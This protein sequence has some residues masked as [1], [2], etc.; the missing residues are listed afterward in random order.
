[1]NVLVLQK[2]FSENAECYWKRGHYY[3]K[4]NDLDNAEE[5]FEKAIELES[6]SFVFHIDLV[7]VLLHAKKFDKAKTGHYAN[8]MPYVRMSS[9]HMS[10]NLKECSDHF[11]PFKI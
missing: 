9:D 7:E 5:D 11:Q 2:W 1:M 3:W 4:T 8:E 10:E 6:S